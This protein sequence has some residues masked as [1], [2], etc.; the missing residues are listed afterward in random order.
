MNTIDCGGPYPPNTPPPAEWAPGKRG[1]ARRL[2][3]G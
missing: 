2:V 1:P 3:I